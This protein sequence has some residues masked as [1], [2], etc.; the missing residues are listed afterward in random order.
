MPHTKGYRA[1]TRH[2]FKKDY[3]TNGVIPLGRY[4]QVYKVGDYVDIKVDSAV[5]KGMPH[6]FYHGR[7][8]IVFNVTNSSVGVV[9]NK[10]V[11]GRIEKKRVNIRVEHVKPSKC[12]VDFLAR[13]ASNERTK[14]ASRKENGVR[15]ELK[16]SAGIPRAGA[17]IKGTK[18]NAEGQKVSVA[19][20]LHPQPYEFI[21]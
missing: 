4:L 21:C 10:L 11:N 6:K 8:G 19:K 2:M 7:T 12:R 14:A 17:I 1:C 20:F 3:K 18:S 16:R 5:Q 15:K 9:V 13:V